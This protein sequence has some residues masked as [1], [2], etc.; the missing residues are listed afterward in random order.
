MQASWRRYVALKN[1]YH[2]ARVGDCF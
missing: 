1:E 2:K